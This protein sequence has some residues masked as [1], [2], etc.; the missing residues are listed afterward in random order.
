MGNIHICPQFLGAGH[1]TITSL[2]NLV[3]QS[4]KFVFNFYVCQAISNL[5]V[6]YYTALLLILSTHIHVQGVKLLVS[7]VFIVVFI[8]TKSIAISRH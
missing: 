3:G 4:V 1:K 8:H 7:S 2:D 6:L 5:S